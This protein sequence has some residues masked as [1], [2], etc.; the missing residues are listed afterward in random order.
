MVGYHP[1]SFHYFFETILLS[2]EITIS[3][4]WS[5]ST[6]PP[7]W[8]YRCAE[9]TSLYVRRDL[10]SSPHACT[11]NTLTIQQPALPLESM[12]SAVIPELS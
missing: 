2:L 9:P 6:P 12:N 3:A 8:G 4:R 1:Q 11:A 5:P 7:H 10:H